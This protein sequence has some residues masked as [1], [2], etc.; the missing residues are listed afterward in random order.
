MPL[1][2]TQYKYSIII[3]T[4]VC[5]LLVVK[6]QLHISHSPIENQDNE[7]RKLIN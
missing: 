6:L 1:H 2:S 3:I 5:C 4:C 7:K